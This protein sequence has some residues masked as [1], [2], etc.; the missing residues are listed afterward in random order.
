MKG[1]DT[2]SE[3]QSKLM[4]GRAERSDKNKSEK[5]RGR[6]SSGGN[7][8]GQ[9]KS[10]GSGRANNHNRGNQSSTGNNTDQKKN[11]GRDLS[12][13]QCFRCDEY[14]HFASNCL[15]RREQK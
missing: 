6:N 11:K 4:F 8:K 15:E 3:D 14:G 7:E 13:I 2:T 12:K 5:G 10:R 1:V 9:N